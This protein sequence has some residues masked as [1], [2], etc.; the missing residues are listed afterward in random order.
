MSDPK[1]QSRYLL[2]QRPQ[3]SGSDS[4]GTPTSQTQPQ[5]DSNQAMAE[6][7]KFLAA[8]TMEM[9]RQ[10]MEDAK[11]QQEQAR[12][13][14]RERRQE[15]EDEAKAREEL[16]RVTFERDQQEYDRRWKLQQK[17]KEERLELTRRAEKAAE[18]KTKQ[19]RNWRKINALPKCSETEDLELFLEGF[20]ATMRQC[21]IPAADW[22]FHLTSLLP[23]THRVPASQAM[24]DG[25]DFDRVKQ[26]LLQSAGYT[27]KRAGVTLLRT[28][29][30]EIRTKSAK[31]RYGL[32]IRLVRRVL[33]PAT[34]KAECVLAIAKMFAREWLGE[35]S[36]SLFDTKTITTHAALQA[37]L[38]DIETAEDLGE[39]TERRADS[40]FPR[41][42]FQR[43]T[44]CFSCGKMGHRAAECRAGESRSTPYPITSTRPVKPPQKTDSS[45]VCYRC[46]QPGH[47]KPDCPQRPGRDAGKE[48]TVQPVK[49]VFTPPPEEESSQGWVEGTVDNVPCKV[50]IDTG[51]S[52]SMVPEELVTPERRTGK[53][54]MVGDANG[55]LVA[56]EL[57][58]ADIQ[59][60]GH[61]RSDRVVIMPSDAP[62]KMVLLS[63]DWRKDA[64]MQLMKDCSA[65]L[66]VEKALAVSTRART[67]QDLER[68]R[69]ELL[70]LEDQQPITTPMD[71]EE[72]P[73]EIDATSGSESSELD[74][75]DGDEM[76]VTEALDQ[77][78]ESEEA[79]P[80]MQVTKDVPS[81]LALDLPLLEDG[82]DRKEICEELL[83]DDSLKMWKELADTGL[84]GFSWEDGLL[85][86]SR[87]G[88]DQEIVRTMIVPKDR[89][90]K[91]MTLAHER[92]GH[93]GYRKV[94]A[95]IKRHF[96]WPTIVRD[97]AT[98]CSSCTVCLACAKS[99][100]WKAPM[101]E[102]PVLTEPYQSIAIDLVGPLPK[103][104]GGVRFVLSYIC[105]AS[106]WPEA[107]ALKS[108]TAKS[109]ATAL[110][111]IFS[112]TALPFRILS[113]Q[114]SQF[115]GAL[116]K[117]LCS[118]WNIDKV[119]T[120]AYHPQTNGQVERMH[121]TLGAMLTKAHHQ[122]FDWAEQ[123]PFA[124]FA[125][126]QSPNRDTGLSPYELVYGANL[127][128]PLDALYHGWA[129]D[130]GGIKVC[131]WVERMAE[132]VELLRDETS[133]KG[134]KAVRKRKKGFDRR[135][136]LRTF[137]AGDRVWQRIPGL[138]HKLQDSWEGPLEVVAR[139]NK[140]NY[141]VR[142]CGSLKKG[143]V[144]HVNTLKRHVSREESVLRLAIVSEDVEEISFRL[145]A[146]H[147][148]MNGDVV[149]EIEEEFADV[150]S[151]IAGNTH[152]SK[153]C[154]D[155]GGAE[156]IVQHSYRLPPKLFEGVRTEL[157]NLLEAGIIEPS[158][159]LWSSPLVPVVKPDGSVR[160]CIDFRK[161]NALTRPLPYHMPT[162]EEIVE[163]VGSSTI[164]SK[165]D[166]TKGYYQVEVDLESRDFT[167]FTCPFGKFRFRRMPFGLK[168]AP[169]IFQELMD[170]VLRPCR[171]FAAD[172]IDDI[173]IYSQSWEEHTGHIRSV[174]EQL[175]SHGLT[176]KP[177][178]C[179]FGMS[180]MYYL[181]HV[182]GQGTLAVP[183]HRVTA[184]ATFRRPMT[185]RDMRSFLGSI[186]YFRRFI[187][188]FGN[189]SA[190]LTP[191]TKKDAPTR[192]QW[193]GEMEAAFDHLK[194]VLC[195]VC[196]LHVPSPQDVFSVETD[197]S[198]LGLGGVLNVV[199]DGE[200][201][202]VGFYSR[203]LRGA[204]HHY[205]ATEL[206]GRAVF[207]TIHHFAHFLYGSA[208]EVYTDHKP[209]EAMNSSPIM[210]RR[211][212]AWTLRL[213]DFQF[214][215]VYR[216]GDQNGGAD[217]LSR[218]GS[219][220]DETTEPDTA[221]GGSE[222]RTGGC[223]ST[224]PTEGGVK[225]EG[226]TEQKEVTES[227]GLKSEGDPGRKDGVPSARGEREK[228]EDSESL[229]D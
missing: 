66:S 46:N 160:I 169:A 8:K 127:R 6:I 193:S 51:A 114:G 188:N 82:S 28:V 50:V 203:Q 40:R 130:K 38:S 131:D 184:M 22:T 20:E 115:N 60:A 47:K 48:K 229:I 145:E 90:V 125:L 204:E 10:K 190:L 138:S 44:K 126:R 122:G 191:A 3:E 148:D 172:Y 168:N 149:N 57:A 69:E 72:Q 89:R 151:M 198:L 23:P 55:G 33:G 183:A 194:L 21:E 157:D 156:P 171:A 97:T 87:L 133:L 112:R 9:E 81:D 54:L 128:T 52:I 220:T 197:A 2:R 221:E 56:R 91:V 32:L 75:V 29:P 16:M 207:D 166:L 76:D 210:N 116:I 134:E 201:L 202:P 124:L 86:R 158:T 123:L 78:L 80:E 181:G 178:K 45:V 65:A 137:E 226:V 18:A 14:E 177:G 174:L 93:L 218:Q 186:G 107:I 227:A 58:T 159:A 173:I 99:R 42:D 189:Y 84:R 92:C 63:V 217:G 71:F 167:T 59:V 17:E 43:S 175:R 121:A 136:K 164:L 222:L 146:T 144:V 129:E 85:F 120:T 118:A 19:D 223:G 213:M 161:I 39:L 68:A 119:R 199:R 36:R 83:L 94:V 109:V 147:P 102:R 73:C 49:A 214:R 77:T 88:I 64:D 225:R 163:R 209:L 219:E 34:D 150:M 180:H 111:E 12:E 206:E 113:D 27:P 176:A 205:S 15:R 162:M 165:L 154:M 196:T 7:L 53:S 212:Q 187:Q 141:R 95:I 170:V 140:V 182:I 41:R 211:L 103:A 96:D 152:T 135:A 100:P 26:T 215:I 37:A 31:D 216:P 228:P 185:K 67:T 208:F 35:T 101:V 25:D 117:C 24:E 70:D 108:I 143:K 106:R 1:E 74:S 4:E 139:L 11:L 62:D 224:A 104:K 142:E 98:H 30:S 13:R 195:S 5:P 105:L 61:T 179:Q 79:S 153:I 132:R 155:L 110:I 200:T 192:V